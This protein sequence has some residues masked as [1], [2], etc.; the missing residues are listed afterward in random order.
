MGIDEWANSIT[1]TDDSLMDQGR[2][3]REWLLSFE[4]QA[5][6]TMIPILRRMLSDGTAGAR[7]AGAYQQLVDETP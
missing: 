5:D 1:L 4:S 2:K 3:L 6:K 7:P